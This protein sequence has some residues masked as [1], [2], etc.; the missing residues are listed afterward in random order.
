MRVLPVVEREL[1]VAARRGG[2]HWGRM[3][4]AAAAVSLFGLVFFL[5]AGDSNQELG[6]TLFVVLAGTFLVV[7]LLMGTVYT[8]DSLSEERR[9]GTLGLLFLTDLRGYDVVLGK[10]VACSVGAVYGMAAIV[11]VLAIPLLLG[12]VS[13]GEFWRVV[14]VLVNTLFLSLSVGMWVSSFMRHS[15]AAMGMTLL[16]VFGV[17]VAGPLV[18][19]GVAYHRGTPPPEAWLM[20]SVGYACVVAHEPF[21]ATRTAEYCASVGIMHLGAWMVLA[22]ASWRAPRAWQEGVT[23]VGMTWRSRLARWL[24]GTDEAHARW[25]REALEINPCYWLGGRTWYKGWVVWAGLV[26]GVMLWLAGYWEWG[27]QWAGD[28]AVALMSVVGAHTVFRWWVAGEA[29]MALGPDRRSGALELVLC[30]PLGVREIVRGR[31]QGLRRQFMGPVGMLLMLDGVLLSMVLG[32]GAEWVD[33]RWWVS[34]YGGLVLVFVLDMVALSW[35]GMWWGL[36]CR[37]ASRALLRSGLLV[38]GMPWLVLVL[39]LIWLVAGRVR[40]PEPEWAYLL[41]AYV[42]VNVMIS[43]CGWQWARER[44]LGRMRVVVSEGTPAGGVRGRGTDAAPTATGR[45]GGR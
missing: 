29:V 27:N 24:R 35:L 4:W 15:L 3:L 32:Q 16:V 19:L 22:L 43:V 23:E 44:L 1:R 20:P 21:Y 17:N 41:G 11:P 33:R 28:E 34:C 30:T 18:G 8:A 14:L 5:G 6:K 25:R 45:E 26:G 2:T 37:Q 12:G 40:L 42:G 39:L 10:L 31:L 13:G 36:T 7:C 38:M 9:Q